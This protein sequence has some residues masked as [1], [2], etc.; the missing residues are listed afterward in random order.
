MAIGAHNGSAGTHDNFFKGSIDD[1]RIYNR[2]LTDQEIQQL[3][4]ENGWTGN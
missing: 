3:Y 2:A 1:I 4:H